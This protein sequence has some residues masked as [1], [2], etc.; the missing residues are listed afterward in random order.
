[1]LSQITRA[2][3]APMYLISTGVGV[4]GTDVRGGDGLREELQSSVSQSSL[5]LTFRLGAAGEWKAV[6]P[7]SK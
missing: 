5:H 7:V 6:P 2:P 3:S 1:M 4:G